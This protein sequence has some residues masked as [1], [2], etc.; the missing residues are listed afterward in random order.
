MFNA[1]VSR[2]PQLVLAA[3]AVAVTA[4]APA[5]ARIDQ[6]APSSAA[7]PSCPS[8]PCLAVTRTTGYQVKLGP[9][10]DLYA[11]PR[12]GRLVAWSVTLGKPGPK[13]VSFFEKNYGGEASAGIAV[14]RTGRRLYARTLALGP[15]ETL[16]PWFGQTVQFAL[17]SSI[18]VHKGEIIGLN[19]PTWA[20]ALQVGLGN[21]SSWRGNRA[22]G[23]CRDTATQS[24]TPSGTVNRFVCL[25]RTARLSYS[26]TIVSTP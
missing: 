4:A 24:Q 14:L 10:R 18:V 2:A 7:S 1:C 11:V 5:S 16:T 20:P 21:D 9:T 15:T 6:I 12:D 13:Q 22:A 26:A 3:L 23:R 17:P 8:S 25:Y 19:V